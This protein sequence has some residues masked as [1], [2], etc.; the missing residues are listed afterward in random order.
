MSETLPTENAVGDDVRLH[1]HL[2]SPM[3][4]IAEGMVRRID[5]TTPEVRSSMVK[6]THKVVLN[7]EQRIVTCNQADACAGVGRRSERDCSPLGTAPQSGLSG[8]Y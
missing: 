1:L 6:I 2:A 4:S 7:R 3:K 8:V 5:V